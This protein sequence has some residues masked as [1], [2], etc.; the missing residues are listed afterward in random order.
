MIELLYIILIYPLEMLIKIIMESFYQLTGNYG[1]SIILV[2]MIISILLYPVDSLSER[3]QEKERFKRESMQ[4][5]LDDLKQS[6][7]GYELHLYIKQL[8]REHNYHPLSELKSSL[9]LIIQLP[10]LFAAYLF[11][12]NYEPLN[13][14]SF[15]L[16]SDLSEPDMLIMIAGYSVN[17]LP[18]MMTIV[19]MAGVYF[20]TMASNIKLSLQLYSMSIIFLFLLYTAPSGLLLYWT[21]RN[22]FSFLKYLVFYLRSLQIQ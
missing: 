14:V 22:V 3:I 20:Y 21:C 15:S 10:F 17:I 16:I 9:G 4:P 12:A 5:Q 8:Y 2:S 1:I 7:N 19:N 18:F 13:G 6:F 11:L